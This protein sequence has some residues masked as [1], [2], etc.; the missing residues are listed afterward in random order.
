MEDAQAQ[1]HS[2]T[3]GFLSAYA[4]RDA[5]P[6]QSSLITVSVSELYGMF[7]QAY[8]SFLTACFRL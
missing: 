6:Y 7:Q 3:A 2:S 1:V 4:V 5:I 8:L